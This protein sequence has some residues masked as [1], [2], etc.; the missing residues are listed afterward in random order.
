MNSEQTEQKCAFPNTHWSQIYLASDREQAQGAK[1]LDELL[2]TYRPSLEA[3]LQRFSSDA[4]QIGEWVDAFVEKRILGKDLLRQANPSKGRFRGFL[5][6]SLDRFV[7][8]QIRWENRQQRKPPGG[9]IPFDDLTEHQTPAGG[10]GPADAGDRAW[11]IRVVEQAKDRAETF[12]RN[13]QKA[14]TWEVFLHG[15][16][17]PLHSGTARPTDAELASLFG[18]DSPSQVS[19]TITT[20]KRKFGNCVREVLSRYVATDSPLEIEEEIQD[21]IAILSTHSSS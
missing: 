15:F 13:K 6:K 2:Q 5:F 16:Y 19:N 17:L 11:A 1:A 12:Y 7:T 21:L 8:D 4:Q 18:F 10:D 20:V 9:T 14:N 3:H